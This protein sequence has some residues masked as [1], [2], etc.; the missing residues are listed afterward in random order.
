MWLIESL[1]IF[2]MRQA[3]LRCCMVISQF[4]FFLVNFSVINFSQ[5]A[6]CFSIFLF[7]LPCSLD[8]AD[9]VELKQEFEE[10]VE[11]CHRSPSRSLSVPSRPRQPQPPQRPPP[12]GQSLCFFSKKVYSAGGKNV[13]IFEM[14][15]LNTRGKQ[16]CK[17]CAQEYFCI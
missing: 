12:P 9:L 17:Y 15:L 7:F 1:G 4:P 3:H 16:G 14:T 2:P 11:F 5:L 6:F 13:R 8:D 10:S